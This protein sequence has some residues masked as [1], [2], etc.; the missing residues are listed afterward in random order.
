MRIRLL[1]AYD[2]TGF[3]GFAANPG[4][5]TVAGELTDALQRVLRRTEPVELT[6]AGRTDKGVHALGQVVTFDVADDVDPAELAR[7]VNRLVSPGIVVRDPSVVPD[8]FDARFSARARTY[9]YI[10]WNRPE[11]DP[12]HAG[13][14]WHV[15][16]P[17]DPALLALACD[18]FIGEHDFAAFCRRATRADGTPASLRRRVHAA[19]WDPGPPGEWRFTIVGSAFCHQMVRSIV[20]IMVDVG[21]RRR[22]AGELLDII[23]SGD[24]AR[25]SGP[26]PPEGL[27]LVGVDYDE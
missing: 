21:R 27:Y 24:R 9:R 14:A 3:H 18:P 8:D 17:L 10:V 2:G 5:R 6:C 4:V 23:A 22:T 20:A 26:A 19:S 1:V 16:E 11:P 15:P 13:R 12:F 25:T 7:R